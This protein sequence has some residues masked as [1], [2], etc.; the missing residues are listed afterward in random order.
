MLIGTLWLPTHRVTEVRNVICSRKQAYKI[1]AE[2][3]WKKVSDTMLPAYQHVVDVLFDLDLE[4]RCIVVDTSILDHATYNRG[5]PEEG[6]YK[7]YF[8]VL[9]HNMSQ[10][11][12]YWVYAD[13]KPNRKRG[14]LLAL[15]AI[16][17]NKA[18]GTW[19]IDDALVKVVEARD[20]RSEDIIQL[21]DILSWNRLEALRGIKT[22]PDGNL[23]APGA[24]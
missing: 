4:Y 23:C 20:S 9:W 5:D 21:V 8:Q 3:K 17:N 12:R 24:G 11:H 6:F 19:N 1:G 16:L 14:R 10:C 22:L 13:Q 15:R 7:F 18:R 2:M